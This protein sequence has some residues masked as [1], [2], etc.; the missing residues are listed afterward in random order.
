MLSFVQSAR[1]NA[2]HISCSPARHKTLLARLRCAAYAHRQSVV[3]LFCMEIANIGDQDVSQSHAPE[4]RRLATR[5]LLHE[6][7]RL[8]P[9]RPVRSPKSAVHCRRPPRQNAPDSLPV[10]TQR[11][12]SI[13][14]RG[15]HL[16]VAARR[17]TKRSLPTHIEGGYGTGP[18]SHA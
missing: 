2:N 17:D 8:Q 12:F 9:A 14:A 5:G 4:R 1:V 10:G 11:R 13:A 7:Q 18:H 15:L 3:P 6:L 16:S